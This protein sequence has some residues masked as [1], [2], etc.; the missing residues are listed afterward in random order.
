MPCGG[1]PHQV[2]TDGRLRYRCGR[3][4]EGPDRGPD[5][6]GKSR[7]LKARVR[8]AG[9]GI[10]WALSE[11]NNGAPNG[12]LHAFNA[13]NVSIELYNTTMNASRDSPGKFAKFAPPTVVNGKVYVP[14]FS[15]KLA[16]YGL[17]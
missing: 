3:A 12:E 1:D 16:V 2:G 17:L 6:F 4:R 13:A 5:G 10:L 14:T 9:T 11:I 7:H 8:G 15:E